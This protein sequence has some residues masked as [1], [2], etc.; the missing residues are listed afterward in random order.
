M[1]KEQVLEVLKALKCFTIKELGNSLVL[2]DN[3]YGDLVVELY[4]D[5][6]GLY[7]GFDM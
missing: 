2:Y 5:D 6:L 3:C 7:D 4:F 1:T